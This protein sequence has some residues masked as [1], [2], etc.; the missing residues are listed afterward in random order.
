LNY[1][2]YVEEERTSMKLE[3]LRGADCTNNVTCPA[4]YSTD[5][6]TIVVQGWAVT[7]P[8]VLRQLTLPMGGL[9]VEVPADLLFEVVTLWPALHRTEYGTLLVPGVT[10]T[11]AEALHQLNLCA[12]E[13]AVEVPTDLLAEVLQAC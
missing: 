5:R 3:L 7:D 8:D 6:G 13:Q 10:V 12:S 1:V 11:D 4:L 2:S 9:A